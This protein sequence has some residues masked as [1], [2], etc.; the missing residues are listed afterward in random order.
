MDKVNEVVGKIIKQVRLLTPEE[1]EEEG[2]DD[3]AF[4]KVTCLEL[5]DGTLLF[6]SRDDEGNGPGTMFGRRGE[7][8]FYV[9]AQTEEVP[10]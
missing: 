5:D 6:A 8:T 9:F 3:Y 1:V 2:W 4:R 10:K 7:D